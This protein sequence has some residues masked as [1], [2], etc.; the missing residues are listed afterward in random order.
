[1]RV[2]V[3]S[4]QLFLNATA[5]PP[6]LSFLGCVSLAVKSGALSQ[7][8]F[9]VIMPCKKHLQTLWSVTTDL[10][11]GCGFGVG[12]GAPDA[13][14]CSLPGTSGPPGGWQR[15]RSPGQPV[16]AQRKAVLHVASVP[17]LLASPLAKPSKNGARRDIPPEAV[18]CGP[19]RE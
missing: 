5:C 3:G 11:A 12:S 19:G 18:R 8:A 9:A 15:L 13:S 14:F 2:E 6:L 16:Q 7:S 10:W 17:L 4:E 1:M